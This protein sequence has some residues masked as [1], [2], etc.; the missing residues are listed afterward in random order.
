M[1]RR[2]GCFFALLFDEEISSTACERGTC[3]ENLLETF[4]AQ[5]FANVLVAIYGIGAGLLS[6]AVAVLLIR[7]WRRARRRFGLR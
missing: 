1:R 7:R 5:T 6:I 4:P 2:V 3:P